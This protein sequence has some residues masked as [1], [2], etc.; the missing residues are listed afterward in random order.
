MTSETQE[1]NYV[2]KNYCHRSLSPQ[3]HLERG[4]EQG[5]RGSELGR[6]GGKERERNQKEIC[7]YIYFY[8][9]E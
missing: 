1:S 2:D 3:D 4:R 8:N 5:E 9:T 6:E 7:F